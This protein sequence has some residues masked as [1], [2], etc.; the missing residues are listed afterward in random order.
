MKKKLTEKQYYLLSFTWGLPITLAGCLIASIL[1]LF[2]KRPK[3]WGYSYYFEVG[4]NWGGASVGIFFITGKY[5]SERLKNHEFGHSIQNCYFG[6]LMPLI[7]NL[8][9]TLRFWYRTLFKI[10][11]PP[12]DSIWFEGQATRLGTW[13]NE[14]TEV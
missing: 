5:A 9:S 13:Y 1:F 7:V 6:F 11:H 12:Y 14:K 2:G 4:K 10:T 8:P 3:K